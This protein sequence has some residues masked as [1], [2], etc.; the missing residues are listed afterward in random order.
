MRFSIVTV[1][2]N[3][4]KTL[5][6]TLQSVSEQRFDS[7][8]HILWDGG[9]TD[10][11]L[12]I[13]R[14]FPHVKIVEGRD[15]GI[16]DAMNKGAAH[17]QGEFLLHLHADDLLAHPEVLH[18]VD[19][20]LRLHPALSWV[21]GLVDVIDE[22]G[23]LLRRP[24][25]VPFEAKRLRKYNIIPHPATF[26]SRALFERMGGFDPDLCYAMDYDLWLRLS[27]VEQPLLLPTVLAHFREHGGSLST[28]E[29][30]RL[31]DEV[32]KV[33][34]RYTRGLWEK[35]RSYRTWKRRGKCTS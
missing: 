7:F 16:A 23:T 5:P 20:T 11:T 29:P 12:A 2:L 13:A 24:P 9:S 31:N 34:N 6:A 35:W 26:V 21:Y 15:R 14:S 22:K 27:S 33:R 1:A 30:R 8:E 28:S 10:E 25:L 3:A 18:Y 4:A 32:Y 19:T 17:A